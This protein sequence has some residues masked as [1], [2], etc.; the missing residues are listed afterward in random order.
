MLFSAA[1]LQFNTCTCL[2]LRLSETTI[3]Q[4]TLPWRS[5]VLRRVKL[6]HGLIYRFSNTSCFSIQGLAVSVTV[7]QEQRV[8]HTD[9]GEQKQNIILLCASA[10]MCENIWFKYWF[11]PEPTFLHAEQEVEVCDVEKIT[12]KRKKRRKN[13][14]SQDENDVTKSHSSKNGASLMKEILSLSLSVRTSARF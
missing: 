1:S 12:D 4:Q 7:I 14:F 6:S 2:K 13:K 5:S 3:L 9:P 10:S 11:Q 8:L